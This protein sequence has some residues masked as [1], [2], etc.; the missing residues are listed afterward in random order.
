[1]STTEATAHQAVPR[2]AKM[3]SKMAPQPQKLHVQ[4][5]AQTQKGMSST[6]D[7][8]MEPAIWALSTVAC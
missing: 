8:S 5:C 1:M 2:P 6:S 3:N 4:H 7:L